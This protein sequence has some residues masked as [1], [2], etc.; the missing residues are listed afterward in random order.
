MTRNSGKSSAVA[1]DDL[2]LKLP[3]PL[4]ARR[5]STVGTAVHS[6]LFRHYAIKWCRNI[7]SLF[8]K[9]CLNAYSDRFRF[10]NHHSYPYLHSRAQRGRRA[11]QNLSPRTR[12]VQF[13]IYPEH[14][15]SSSTSILASTSLNVFAHP[16]SKLLKR[17]FRRLIRL[18]MFSIPQSP[19]SPYLSPTFLRL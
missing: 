18:R 16:S 3:C 9:Y 4:W 6:R 19:T 8:G 1:E 14:I 5:F 7:V 11:S 12:P 17:S 15:L 10:G 13:C 2:S